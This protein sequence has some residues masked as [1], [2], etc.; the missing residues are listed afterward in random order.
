MH[1]GPDRRVELLVFAPVAA[2]FTTLY[3]TQPVLQ[4]KFGV[5]VA[6]LSVSAVLLP[7]AIGMLERRQPA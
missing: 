2:A 4:A 6:S 3:I 1:P 5:S 7:I